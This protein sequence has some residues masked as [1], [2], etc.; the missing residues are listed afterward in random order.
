MLASASEIQKMPFVRKKESMKLASPN[1]SN[2]LPVK[3]AASMPSPVYQCK[4]A[5][6]WNMIANCSPTRYR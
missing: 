3:S 2:I 5:L 4:K 1:N 6:R